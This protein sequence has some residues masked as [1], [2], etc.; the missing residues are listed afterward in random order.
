[1]SKLSTF[2]ENERGE[3]GWSRQDLAD[4]SGIPYPTISRWENPRSRAKPD[5]ENVQALARAFEM[6]AQRVLALIG[7]PVRESV[8]DDERAQRWEALRRL[9]EADPRAERILELYGEAD[10]A[11]RDT[12]LTI[13]E[14][15]FSHR[16]RRR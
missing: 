8:S 6:P 9:L 5:H 4:V 7:Y 12:G 13:L 14:A 1:M 15:H 11:E 3:R 10:D 16:R 2:L